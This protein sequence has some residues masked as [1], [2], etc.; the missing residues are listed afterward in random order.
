MIKYGEARSNYFMLTEL[1]VRLREHAERQKEIAAAELQKLH[2]MEAKALQ[3]DGIVRDKAA[4][5]AA[6]KSLEEI[7][8]RIEEPRKSAM[9]RFSSSARLTPRP[10]TKSRGKRSTCRYP[11]SRARPWPIFTCRPR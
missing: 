7:E 6:Q 9:Q 4:L 1:P 3:V 5:A 8:A 2:D 10:R 11:K